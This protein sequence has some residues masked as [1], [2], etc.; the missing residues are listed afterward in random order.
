MTSALEN[1]EKGDYQIEWKN[2]VAQ[3]GNW[4]EPKR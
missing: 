2:Y 4:I 3:T 1:N